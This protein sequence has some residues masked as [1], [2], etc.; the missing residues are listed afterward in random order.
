M[1]VVYLSYDNA[2]YENALYVARELEANGIP[3]VFVRHNHFFA[4]GDVAEEMLQGIKDSHIVLCV[5]SESSNE[6]NFVSIEIN[7]AVKRQ[8]TVCVISPDFSQ[9]NSKNAFALSGATY[10]EGVNFK[11]AVSS[12]IK[13][14]RERN[15]H[16]G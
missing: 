9:P 6:S 1:S 8:K 3:C 14:Y 4:N 13:W 5:F 10:I 7:A 2:D 12:F 15:G 16:G 11:G